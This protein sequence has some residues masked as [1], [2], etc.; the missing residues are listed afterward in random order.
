MDEE[1]RL[2]LEMI[3]KQIEAVKKESVKRRASPFEMRDSSG[4]WVLTNL[5]LA[6][7]MTM[8]SLVICESTV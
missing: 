3:N 4:G 8:G 7:A 2:L 5:L 1:L 6:K